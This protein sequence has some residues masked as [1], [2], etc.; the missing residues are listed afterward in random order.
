MPYVDR[1]SY[2]YMYTASWGMST[3][4]PIHKGGPTSACENYRGISVSG[5]LAK[6]YAAIINRRLAPWTECNN[7]RCSGQS[8]FRRR[9]SAI[10]N[11]LILR[12]L[13]D[14]SRRVQRVIGSMFASSILQKHTIPF[15]DTY[16]YISSGV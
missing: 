13:I 10:D 5:A 1:I 3:I 16:Y 2:M 7:I 6:L 4:V 12:T 15:P 11:L 9:H 14:L 8:G